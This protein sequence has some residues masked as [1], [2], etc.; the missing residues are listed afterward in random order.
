[1]SRI[2]GKTILITGASSG[3]GQACAR[4]LGSQRAELILWARRENRLRDLAGELRNAYGIEVT[5]SDVDVRDRER[6][7]HEADWCAATDNIPHILINNAGLARGLTKLHDGDPVDWDEMIDTNINGL[8]NVTRE[9]V[10]LMI[11]E[12]RGHIINIGSTAGH[13]TY[14]N[15]NVYA[16]SKAFVRSVSEGMNLDLAGTPLKVTC[17]SPGYVHTEFSTVRFHGDMSR[18]DS[19]Y[20]GFKALTGDDIADTI[21]YICNLPDYM[22]ILDVVIVPSAQRNIYVVDRKE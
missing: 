1:M 2:S 17:V 6:V 12:G 3:I 15:G 21:S 19:V 20:K 22:N 10:P 11:R 16:A 13:T 14:P 5:A 8:L 4:N 9:I 18:A 7:K